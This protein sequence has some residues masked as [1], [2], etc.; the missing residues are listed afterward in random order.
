MGKTS[1]LGRVTTFYSSWMQRSVLVV[2]ELLRVEIN[3]QVTL[4]R[5][6]TSY[7][8]CSLTKKLFKKIN[9][10][11]KNCFFSPSFVLQDSA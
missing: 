11:L 7:V 5:L 8:D 9:S 10:L 1:G 3:T 2:S 6:Q 4:L